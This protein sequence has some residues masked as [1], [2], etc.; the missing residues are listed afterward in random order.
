M[1]N[2]ILAASLSLCLTIG[3]VA[4]GDNNSTDV[5]DITYDCTSSTPTYTTDIKPIMDSQ[6]ATSGC[7]DATTRAEGIDLSTYASVSGAASEKKFRGSIEHL[8]GYKEM[9][10]RASKLPDSDLQKI[11]C[12]IE[13]GKPQ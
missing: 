3:L 5:E 11:Y 7:H 4:C 6:C 13:S 12:W 10:E 8:S 2:K 1:N 9:P